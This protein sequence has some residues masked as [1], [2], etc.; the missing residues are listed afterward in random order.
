MVNGYNVYLVLLKGKSENTIDFLPEKNV[1]TIPLREIGIYLR[2]LNVSVVNL[3]LYSRLLSVVLRIL[4][5]KI[6][7]ISTLHMPINSWGVRQGKCMKNRSTTGLVAL[8]QK[9]LMWS[10][11]SFRSWMIRC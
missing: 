10:F 4:T 1:R 6:K 9:D 7:I 3:H 2:T 8:D 5:L 11:S